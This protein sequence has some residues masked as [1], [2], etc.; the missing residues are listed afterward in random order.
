MAVQFLLPTPRF[1]AIR[2]FSRSMAPLFRRLRQPRCFETPPPHTR[3]RNRDRPDSPPL[4]RLA[5]NLTFQV[6]VA[7][8]AGVA[9]GA[10]RPEYGVAMKPLGDVFINLVKM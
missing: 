5:R 6:L 4:M 10:I 3:A 1:F 2:V 7:V 8:A 9:L